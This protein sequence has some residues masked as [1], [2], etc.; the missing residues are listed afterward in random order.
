MNNSSDCFSSNG[1]ED[2]TQMVPATSIP[3]MKLDGWKS[4]LNNFKPLALQ[5]SSDKGSHITDEANSSNKN[6]DESMEG[7]EHKLGNS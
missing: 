5:S 4:K 7:E 2:I 1:K 6:R 3:N